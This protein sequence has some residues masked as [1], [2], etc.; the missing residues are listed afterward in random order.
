MHGRACKQYT[1]RSYNTSALNAMCF[2]ETPL[3][4]QFETENKKV[5]RFRFYS[6]SLVVLLVLLVVFKQHPGS[7]GVNVASAINRVR[8]A[9][10]LCLSFS[11]STLQN[12]VLYVFSFLF[13]TGKYFLC[14]DIH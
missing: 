13:D 6:I 8:L 7:E 14:M 4:C 3:T 1:F 10:L 9:P 12:V 5:K 2:D 11:P